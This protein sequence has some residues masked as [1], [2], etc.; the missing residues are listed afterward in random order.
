MR[1]ASAAYF[2]FTLTKIFNG[3]FVVGGSVGTCVCVCVS[4]CFRLLS[5]HMHTHKKLDTNKLK[6][7]RT[8][9]LRFFRNVCKIY[10]LFCDLQ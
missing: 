6:K 10:I 5:T 7:K 4:H 9:C 2:I 1:K 3:T 8:Q